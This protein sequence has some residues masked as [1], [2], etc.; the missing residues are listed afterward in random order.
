MHSKKCISKKFMV[1]NSNC[2]KNIGQ[3]L[4]YKIFDDFIPCCDHIKFH[5]ITFDIGLVICL[6]RFNLIKILSNDRWKLTHETLIV[7]YL[8]LIRSIIDYWS[9]LIPFITE[10]NK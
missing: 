4:K 7:I 5:A 8:A 9:L 6:N 2:N 1:F 10:N 3:K